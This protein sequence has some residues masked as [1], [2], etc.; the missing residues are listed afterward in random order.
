MYEFKKILHESDIDK[1]LLKNSLR[2]RPYYDFMKR[3]L[4]IIIALTGMLFFPLFFIIISIAIKWDSPGKVIFK[5]KRWYDEKRFFEMLKFRTMV[6]EAD[7]ILKKDKD[8]SQQF[9]ENAKLKEDPRLTKLGR[10]LRKTSLDEIPQIINVLKGEMSIVGP[11]PKLV[12]EIHRY[13]IYKKY[14]LKVKPGVTGYWQITGRND[15]SYEQRILKDVYYVQNRSFWYDILII[16]K[17]I[18]MVITA[19][20]AY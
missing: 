1:N 19:K 4:D 13:G 8:L 9:Y 7:L 12:K 14:V 6:E 5:S 3:V 18:F 15:S 17:T 16:I 20:G 10:F 11:R 2:N